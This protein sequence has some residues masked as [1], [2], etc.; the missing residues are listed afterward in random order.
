MDIIPHTYSIVGSIIATIP[1]DTIVAPIQS[2]GLYIGLTGNIIQGSYPKFHKALHRKLK[3]SHAPE[4]DE[5]FFI[6]QPPFSAR[7][8]NRVFYVID[9]GSIPLSTFTERLLYRLYTND[10]L[11]VGLPILRYRQ[12]AVAV[13]IRMMLKGI[14]NFQNTCNAPMRIYITIPASLSPIPSDIFSQTVFLE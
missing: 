7:T 11:I 6:S 9:D 8:F 4:N 2:N 3:R 13:S 10:C 5:G 14:R 12:E 1:F